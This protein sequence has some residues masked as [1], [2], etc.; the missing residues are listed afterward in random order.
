MPDYSKAK[1][2]K[3]VCNISGETYYG[4][5]TQPLW[6][7]MGHHRHKS[8][9]A[10]SKQI[11]QRGNYDYVLVEDYPCENKE[12]LHKQE[13]FYIENNQCINTIIPTRTDKEYSKHWR[14]THKEYDKERR[15]RYKE[16]NKLYEES[17]KEKIICECGCKVSKSWLREHKKTDIHKNKMLV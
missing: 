4:S 13:R 14:E 10:N 2:Y 9:N 7:R 1:I 11:I 5:T 12:Q 3:I 6:K 15:A 17:M 8:N 16:Q